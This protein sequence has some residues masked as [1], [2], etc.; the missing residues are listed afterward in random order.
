MTYQEKRR[1]KRVGGDIAIAINDTETNL[2]SEVK[3]ISLSGISFKL[4]KTFA[5][6][7]KVAVTLLLPKFPGKTKKNK[8]DVVGIVVRSEPFKEDP[9]FF[10]TA[11]F[12]HEMDKQD[13][14]ILNNY[15]SYMES[16]E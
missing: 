14:K 5:P 16:K 12:F 4:T 10:E 13:L 9:T 6:M 3:D 11:V 1:H 7:T 15:V 2:I 8:L